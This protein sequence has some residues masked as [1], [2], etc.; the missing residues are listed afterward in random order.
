V[1]RMTKENARDA[2]HGQVLRPDGTPVVGAEIALGTLEHRVMLGRVEFTKRGAEWWTTSD[3][4]G[5]FMF[6]PEPEAHTV[7]AVDEWGF[8]AARVTR[9]QRIFKLVLQPWGRIEGQVRGTNLADG[10]YAVL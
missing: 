6:P 2:V 10:Q 1:F 4:A 7:Y 5:A 3:V 8:A 9:D